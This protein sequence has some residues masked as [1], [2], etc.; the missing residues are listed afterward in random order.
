MAKKIHIYLK[1]E[2]AFLTKIFIYSG[3]TEFISTKYTYTS[4]TSKEDQK[5]NGGGEEVA[6]P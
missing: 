1:M 2:F 3:G 5:A 4:T 6:C